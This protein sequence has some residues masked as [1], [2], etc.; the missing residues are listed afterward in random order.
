RM[1]TGKERLE[2]WM[3]EIME[4]ELK[5][6][7]FVTGHLM[8]TDNTPNIVMSQCMERWPNDPGNRFVGLVMVAPHNLKGIKHVKRTP[9]EC[10]RVERTTVI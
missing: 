8:C 3:G 4:L 7:R 5:D 2:E 9:I 1:T 6:G 10:P